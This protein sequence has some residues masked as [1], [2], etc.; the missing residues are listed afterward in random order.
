MLA[1]FIGLSGWLIVPVL[2][3]PQE[4]GLVHLRKGINIKKE[5]LYFRF[6]VTSEEIWGEW[7]YIDIKL[8]WCNIFLISIGSYLGIYFN[9][10]Y[11]YIVL[12]RLYYFEILDL[13]SN[14]YPKE[15]P[16]LLLNWFVYHQQFPVSSKLIRQ[17]DTSLTTLWLFRWCNN[18]IIDRRENNVMRTS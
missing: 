11:S 6:Y 18:T 13:S 8:V 7:R 4:C 17:V 2:E 5:P 16:I 14:C 1:L 10:K 12:Y 9:F 15:K 3:H